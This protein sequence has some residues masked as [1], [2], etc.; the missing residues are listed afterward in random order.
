MVHSKRRI[1]NNL[2][3]A[4]H[5]GNTCWHIIFN[6]QTAFSSTK[7]DLMKWSKKIVLILILCT[8]LCISSAVAG[9][10]P[11]IAYTYSTDS[12]QL[13]DAGNPVFIPKPVQMKGDTPSDQMYVPGVVIV[14]YEEP[15]MAA[16]DSQDTISSTVNAG[17]GA[18]VTESYV[19]GVLPGYQVVSLPESMTVDLAIAYYENQPGV[20]YAQPNYLYTIDA[21]PNDPSYAL[22]WGLKNTGQTTPYFPSGGTTGADISAEDAWD[23]T[24]GSDDIVIAVIDSGVDYLHEDLAPNMWDDGSGH[25]GYDFLNGDNDPMDDNS[26]GT[27]CAGIIAAAGNN[28]IGVTGV[29]WDAKIMALKYSDAEGRGATATAIEAINYA[30]SHGADILSCSWGGNSYDDALKAAIDN[31]N[32]LVVCAVGNEGT[33]NDADPRYPAT[34]DSPNI[35]AVAATTPE[36]TLSDFSNYGATS[37]DIAAPGS[38]I[39]ST[40]PHEVEYVMTTTVF[41]DDMSSLSGWEEWDGTGSNRMAWDLDTTKYTSAP[42]SAATGPYG[43]DW[44]QWLS[45]TDSISLGGLTHPGLRFERSYDTEIAYDFACVGISEDGNQYSIKGISGNSGGFIEETYDLTDF[46]GI[47]Y[48]GKNIWIA[49]ILVSNEFTTGNG[50]WVDDIRVGQLEQSNSISQYAYKSGTSMATPLVSG[51]AG[52]VMAA[53]PDYTWEEV[54]AEIL[55]NTD[56]LPALTGKCVTGGRLSVSTE[57]AI[58]LNADF[59]ADA[60]SGKLPFTV[61]FTDTS[62]GDPTVW[63][64]V[65]GNGDTSTTQNPSCTYTAAGNYTVSLTVEDVEGNSDTK[66]KE[67]YITVSPGTSPAISL[68]LSPASSVVNIGTDSVHSVILDSVP[69]GLAG[70]NLTLS[71]S[72]LTVGEIVDISAPAW[73]S[74]S[75]TSD[76]PADSVWISSVDL[77]SSVNPG[78]TDVL[79]GNV[80]VR[81]DVEG[82]TELI[83]IVNQMDDDSGNT[84]TPLT[85]PATIAVIPVNTMEPFPGASAPPTD[86]DY[87]G[88]FEDI[89]GNGRIDFADVVLYFNE[90]EWIPDHEQISFFDFNEN[91]RIDFDDVVKLFNEV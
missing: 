53:H 7:G 43:N 25:C 73:A 61:N 18:L 5:A 16:T 83:I 64:W 30:V 15:E 67:R 23:V 32:I 71:L 82:T 66:T 8:G 77:D 90:M 40:V 59:I 85:E 21:V 45:T 29:C 37:V 56:P 31:S 52:L 24:T 75:S 81:G 57:E 65:F 22:Q 91:G 17:I 14:V 20:K 87:D 72:N 38:D 2:C 54:K 3:P 13:D 35:L 63:A 89:N 58:Q 46:N 47:D 76:V 55:D 6:I 28:G 34:Y 49:M 79:L 19:T 70:Y 48:T 78:E 84:I 39:Y 80:T 44:M 10:S 27:H 42:S 26:H 12:I 88:L 33:D 86:P 74:M 1:T 36:D 4:I 60:T 51:A 9:I 68:S 69:E 50:V 11:E 62:T 41:S